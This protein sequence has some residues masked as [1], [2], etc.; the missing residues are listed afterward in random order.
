MIYTDHHVHS[1]YSPDS[2]A[3][4]KE[5]IIKAK[6]MGLDYIMFT[7]HTDFG[8][9]DKDFMKLIDYDEYFNR[10]NGLQEEFNIPI[11][12]GVEIGYEK[13][14][15]NEIN[16]FLNKYPFDFVI[17]SIHYGDDKDFY[18]GDFFHGKTQEQSYHRYFEILLE[19]VENFSNFD[20]VGHLDYITRYGPFDN[21]YYEYER[22]KE[23][24]D[25][26]LKVI[27]NKD[28]GIELNTS[29]M[30]KSSNT[31]FPKKEVLKRYKDLGGKIITI[32][33]DAHFNEHYSAGIVDGINLLKSI[34]YDQISYFENRM[35]KVMTI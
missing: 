4:I 27:I 15:K 12:I 19:M 1:Y 10:M 13:N 6:E 29:G 18:R 14:Y 20:V 7:D 23:I 5:Y 3:D 28:K 24:I 21:K 2:K 30:R 9:T 33:S 22:F 34:G 35:K 25:A 32:G 11:K 26:I 31:F 8:T 16:D 17:F